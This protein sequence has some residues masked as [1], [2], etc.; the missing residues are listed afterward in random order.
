MQI[1]FLEKRIWLG[2]AD[3][4]KQ[5]ADEK[6][7]DTVKTPYDNEKGKI[8]RHDAYGWQPKSLKHG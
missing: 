8:H 4:I 7:T 1:G 5:M 6:K 2:P 3:M